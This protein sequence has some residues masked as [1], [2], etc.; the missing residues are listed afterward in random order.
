MKM[1]LGVLIFLTHSSSQAEVSSNGGKKLSSIQKEEL[2]AIQD[3]SRESNYL[4]SKKEVDD[5]LASKVI[6]PLEH[7]KLLQFILK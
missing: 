4:L 2:L 3:L 5:L 1:L 7:K 6:T